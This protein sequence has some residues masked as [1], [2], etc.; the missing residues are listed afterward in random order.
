M[1]RSLSGARLQFGCHEDVKND[2]LS[3][4]SLWYFLTSA[5]AATTS[6]SRTTAVYSFSWH[7][8]DPPCLQGDPRKVTDVLDMS[9]HLVDH[10]LLLSA[11]ALAAE[12]HHWRPAIDSE[13]VR[14]TVAPRPKRA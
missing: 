11:Q 9:S 7:T 4:H 2:T 5:G 14:A 8:L 12:S 1:E 6:E 13:H 10:N 3:A